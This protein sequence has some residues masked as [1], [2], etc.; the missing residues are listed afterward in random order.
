MKAEITQSSRGYRWIIRSGTNI[1][2][3]SRVFYK[4]RRDAVRGFWRM[5]AR[6]T[7]NV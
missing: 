3:R 1:T 6:M 7:R 4:R 5:V 2:G